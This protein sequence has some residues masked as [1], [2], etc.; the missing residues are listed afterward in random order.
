VNV[1]CPYGKGDIFTINDVMI[2]DE[3]SDQDFPIVAAPREVPPVFA[4]PALPTPVAV[5][6]KLNMEDAIAEEADDDASSDSALDAMAAAA[7]DDAS[8]DSAADAINELD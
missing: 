5:K 1:L 4:A 7:M 6:R 2:L 8:L 3:D